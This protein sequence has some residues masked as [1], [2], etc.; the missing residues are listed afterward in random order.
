ML[1]AHKNKVQK[2]TKSEMGQSNRLTI[3]LWL[4]HSGG[5]SP[6]YL[7]AQPHGYSS[8]VRAY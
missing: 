3:V 5:S 6:Q 4:M 7:G 2:G 1:R 8:A